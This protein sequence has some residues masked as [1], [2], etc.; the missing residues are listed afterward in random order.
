[1]EATT[2]QPRT[3]GRATVGEVRNKSTK[4][5]IKPNL[6][7]KF[8]HAFVHRFKLCEQ[9]QWQQGTCGNLH[10]KWCCGWSRQ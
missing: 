5:S 6:F 3:K 8:K 10:W 1:M 2:V 9:G 7:Q 4:P